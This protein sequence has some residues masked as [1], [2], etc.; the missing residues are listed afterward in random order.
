[1]TLGDL[2]PP[3]LRRPARRAKDALRRL[4]RPGLTRDLHVRG[5]GEGEFAA[6][7]AEL[8]R[9]AVDLAGL[10]PSDRVLDAGCGLGRLAVPLAG[11][12]G[13]EGRYT[14]FDVVED[15]VWW[16]RRQF[17]RRD[18][19]FTFDHAD[20]RS[21]MYNPRGRYAPEQFR[22]PY[23]DASFDVVLAFSLFTHLEAPAAARYLAESA[24]V[25]RPGGRLLATFFFLDEDAEAAIAAGH[26]LLTFRHRG[27]IGDMGAL[28]DPAT[29]ESAVALPR[30]WLDSALADAGLTLRALHPGNWTGR[31]DCVTY[32]DVVVA[33]RKA[34]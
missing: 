26:T 15:V 9:L 12:L 23:P 29:P 18:P 17:G 24:R 13:P 30:P 25:L 22:F 33:E 28:E 21:V 8:L 6:V 3:A 20:V 7:G 4:L 34:G 2:L 16:N 19:R 5:I 27:K 32:Q 14:G 11:Y 31:P 1:M 10:G